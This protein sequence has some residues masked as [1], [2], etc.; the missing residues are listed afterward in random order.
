[1]QILVSFY[2][3]NNNSNWRHLRETIILAVVNLDTHS[4]NNTFIM[5]IEDTQNVFL[6]PHTDKSGISG[7]TIMDGQLLA[8]SRSDIWHAPLGI[9][10]TEGVDYVRIFEKFVLSEKGV[11]SNIHQIDYV[12][13][14]GGVL[15]ADTGRNKVKLIK[16]HSILVVHDGLGERNHINSVYATE[17]NVYFVYHNNNDEGIVVDINNSRI[18]GGLQHPHNFCITALGHLLV[19]DSGN[20]R[21]VK[22]KGKRVRQHVD[23]GAWTRGLAMSNDFDICVGTSSRA[24]GCKIYVLDYDLQVKD[25]LILSELDERFI[26]EIYD[27]RILPPAIDLA[28]SQCY[29][30]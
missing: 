7:I 26:G 8:A 10:Y 16:N 29:K 30:E 6:C 5:N 19:C 14:L 18:V 17:D 3:N 13:R 1:M 11:G 15:Y 20:N 22:K 2:I 25:I 28:M 9:I 4:V 12:P 24:D 27:I 21:L 23:L